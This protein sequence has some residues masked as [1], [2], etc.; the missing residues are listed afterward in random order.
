V[1]YL[2]IFNSVDL[3]FSVDTGVLKYGGLQGSYKKNIFLVKSLIEKTSK[4]SD[5]SIPY[6]C[7]P[8]V[9]TFLR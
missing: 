2:T 6:W 5:F 3:Y 4:D 7:S 9:T 1:V 8:S